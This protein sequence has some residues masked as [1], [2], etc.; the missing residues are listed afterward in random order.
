MLTRQLAAFA[1]LAAVL[2]ACG[3]PTVSPSGASGAPGGSSVADGY[4]ELQG[5]TP[6]EAARKSL[7]E[8][9]QLV[10]PENFADLGFASAEEAAQAELGRPIEVAIVPLNRLRAYEASQDPMTLLVQGGEVVYEVTV[11]GEV[12]TGLTV[13]QRG[14]MWEGIGFGSRNLTAAIASAHDHE[15]EFAVW[16]PA[17]NFWAIAR[18]ADGFVLAPLFDVPDAGLVAG[19]EVPAKNAFQQLAE[20]AP[21]DDE[22]T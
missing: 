10:T 19:A 16:V 1:L 9:R 3:S 22:L 11:A 13:D 12:R 14:G 17:M 8:F 4:A 2:A 7:D 21:A 15:D 18:K 5:A 6:E 20:Q